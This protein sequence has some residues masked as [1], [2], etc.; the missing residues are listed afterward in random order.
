MRIDRRWLEILILFIG[1]P[2]I[3]GT[4]MPL[5]WMWTILILAGV[6]G[7]LLLIRTPEFRWRDLLTGKL[8]WKEIGLLCLVTFV[9]GSA[10]CAIFLPDRLWQMLREFPLFLPILAV[11]YS[12]VLVTPQEIIYRP[13]FYIRYGELFKTRQQAILFNAAL[14]SFGH[15]LYW[16][17]IVFLLTFIGSIIFSKAYFSHGFKQA[18]A[19]HAVAGIAVFASGLGWLF[20]TGGNVAQ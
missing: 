3:M 6:F 16:N 12:L 8:L 5:D 1:L 15:L 14:F 9:A 7:L 17:V 18:W 20:Y 10:L 13:L 2:L 19:L 11:V 4:V